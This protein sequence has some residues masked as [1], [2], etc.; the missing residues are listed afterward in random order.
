MHNYALYDCYWA[1]TQYG[2][3]TQQYDVLYSGF[4]T[5]VHCTKTTGFGTV[6]H[7]T[8]TTVPKAGLL[9]MSD[10]VSLL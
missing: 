6:V 4:G 8:K 3:R 1:Y 7:C 5:V 9:H 2:S 10:L